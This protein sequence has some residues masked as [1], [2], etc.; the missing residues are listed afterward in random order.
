ML[1]DNYPVGD[2]FVYP[3]I[4]FTCRKVYEEGIHILYGNNTFLAHPNLLS[5]LPRLRSYYDTIVS[6]S[7]ITLIRRYQ[8]RIRLDC[9]P[10]FTAEQATHAF[11]GVDELN[12]I[13][14]QAQYGSSDYKVLRLFEGVRGVKRINI[15][16]SI[17]LFREYVEWLRQAMSAPINETVEEFGQEKAIASDLGTYDL[18]TVSTN[19]T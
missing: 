8:I 2:P 1:P 12:I 10:N 7:L 18:W 17:T 5:A 14:F 11:T 3:H 15:C 4:L 19:A 16:G 6:P 13:V 9:D